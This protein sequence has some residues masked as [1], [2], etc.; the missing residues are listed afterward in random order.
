MA[1]PL[2]ARPPC[3]LLRNS[4]EQD[5]DGEVMSPKSDGLSGLGLA[6]ETQ[7]RIT[8]SGLGGRGQSDS[9]LKS[10]YQLGGGGGEGR[11]GLG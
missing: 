2:L 3:P 4:E 6:S 11:T 1:R 8:Q 9:Q 5:P 10:L 7:R